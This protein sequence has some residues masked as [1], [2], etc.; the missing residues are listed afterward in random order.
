[1][2]SGDLLVAIGCL[3]LE[4]MQLQ[5]VQGWSLAST[6]LLTFRK[7]EALRA[8]REE[9]SFSHAIFALKT[10]VPIALPLGAH[11]SLGCR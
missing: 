5:D 2:E 8:I 9:S 7:P 1:M 3:P 11:S 6:P 10:A 4:Y